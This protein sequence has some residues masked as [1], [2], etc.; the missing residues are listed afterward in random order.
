MLRLLR[1]Y[2]LHFT[3]HSELLRVSLAF[4]Q[5][6]TTLN[7][8]M[9]TTTSNGH[10]LITNLKKAGFNDVQAEAVLDTVKTAQKES[11]SATKSDLRELE[12]RMTIKFLLMQGATIGILAVLIKAL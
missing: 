12:Y 3:R 2:S 1:C 5:S 4:N 8:D 6:L 7:T 10:L 9:S 11:A